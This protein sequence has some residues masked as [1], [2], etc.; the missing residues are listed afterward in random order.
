ME[1]RGR[2]G[3]PPRLMQQKTLCYVVNA[4][5]QSSIIARGYNRSSSQNFFVFAVHTL[6]S[7][8]LHNLCFASSM[9]SMG[10]GLYCTIVVALVVQPENVMKHFT[11]PVLK[12]DRCLRYLYVLGCLSNQYEH[13]LLHAPTIQGFAP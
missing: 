2:T 11:T 13:L 4:T 1:T 12:C 7:T 3:T 10:T 8:V 5:A 9:G 6:K